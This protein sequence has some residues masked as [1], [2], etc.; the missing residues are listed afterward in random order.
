MN[1]QT[2]H[3][4]WVK[5]S[6]WIVTLSFLAL[7]VS[8]VAMVMTHPRFYWGDTG[9]DLT[10][11]L[12]ELP[13]SRNYKH[14]GW[15]KPAP[16]FDDRPEISANRTYDIFNENGWGRSLHFLSAWFMVFTGLVYFLA[17]IFTGHFRKHLVPKRSELKPSLIR[18]DLV[19]HLRLTVPPPTGGPHYG[20]LQKCTYAS[21]IFIV[22][23]V[24]IL[25][26]LAMSPA[27]NAAYPFISEMFG[28]SQSARTIHFFVSVILV[29][30]LCMHLLMLI[31]SG[32]KK[33]FRDMTIG[34]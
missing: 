3:T 2:P 12:F 16:F 9:N 32:F 20:T 5:S 10:P 34:N 4:R 33:H 13:V 6:H 27:V 17:G 14:N 18:E 7:T 15:E 23:P 29:L 8:G 22:F 24:A 19:N 25:T 1:D 30:F 11:A 28:G 21:I 26:G 31:R